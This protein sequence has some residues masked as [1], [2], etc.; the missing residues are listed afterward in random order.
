FINYIEKFDQY[1]MLLSDK[2][3]IVK[4]TNS[5]FKNEEKKHDFNNCKNNMQLKKMIKSDNF[6]NFDFDN[7]SSSSNNKNKNKNENKNI[8]ENKILLLNSLNLLINKITSASAFTLTNSI[9]TNK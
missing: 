7:E 6:N 8:D 9:V 2:Q 1:L 5:D 3:R 4:T